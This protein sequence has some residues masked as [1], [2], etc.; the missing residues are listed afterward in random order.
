MK[1]HTHYNEDDVTLSDLVGSSFALVQHGIDKVVGAGLKL[2]R[3]TAETPRKKPG[4][5]NTIL[6]G[7]SGFTRG[8]IGFVARA[9]DSYMETY[10]R[11]KRDHKN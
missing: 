7:V 1:K 6:R 3:K 5:S 10:N 11:L 9:G 2:L 4:S 8:T